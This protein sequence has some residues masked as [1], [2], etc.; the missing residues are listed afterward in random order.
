MET[1]LKALFFQ[2]L[3]HELLSFLI[4]KFPQELSVLRAFPMSSSYDLFVSETFLEGS[5]SKGLFH[6]VLLL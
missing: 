1:F 4:Q 3:S 2:S 5:L 6:K